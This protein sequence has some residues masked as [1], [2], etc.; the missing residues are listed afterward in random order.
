[1]KFK[2]LAVVCL[3][4]LGTEVYA[5]GIRENVD[6]TDEVSRTSYAIGMTLGLDFADD[7][8]EIDY[9]AFM[10]GLIAAM[11]SG[12]EGLLLDP[13]E[14]MELI[15]AAFDRAEQRQNMSLHMEEELFLAANAETEGITVTESGLQYL[16]IQLGDGP[17]PS[18]TDVVLVHY[19]GKLLNGTVFDS[20]HDR[21]FPEEV[22]LN[23]V[24]PGWTES[25]QLMPVGSTFRVYIPSSLAYGQAGAGSII[26][27]F[28][29]LVF[30]IELLDIL[31]DE[32]ELDFSAEEETELE[33][34][35]FD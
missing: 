6:M 35:V 27:P 13:D 24:I 10:E 3:F 9:L 1:M 30:T 2:F 17:K 8:L 32:V 25:L 31:V 23:M 11:E 29:T 34:H 4:I 16:V 33:E 26:P 14:A 21:G 20:S 15:L 22:P 12:G 7:N 28:S 18:A 19:V 5:R